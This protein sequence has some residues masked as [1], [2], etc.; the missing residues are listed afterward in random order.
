[1]PADEIWVKLGGDK[2]G[3]SVK[4]NFQICN[5]QKPNSVTNT[6]VFTAYEAADTKTNLHIAL[7]KYKPQVEVLRKTVWRYRILKTIH[8][9][10]MPH[11]YTFSPGTL[12]ARSSR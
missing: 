4:I 9:T 10:I 3:G 8:H 5:C 6:C 2:G 1:M 11:S 12:Q 7:D